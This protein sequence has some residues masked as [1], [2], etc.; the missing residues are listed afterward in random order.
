MAARCLKYMMLCKVMDKD[1]AGIGKFLNGKAMQGYIN[2][3]EIQALQE[4][5]GVYQQRNMHALSETLEKRRATLA[6]DPVV[7]GHLKDL[8]DM[9]FEAHI[10][11]LISPYSR[12][13]VGH[14]ASK[15]VLPTE[16]IEAKLC[17]MILDKKIEG[18]I[19]VGHDKQSVLLLF[20]VPEPLDAAGD[21]DEEK[22][23]KKT[24]DPEEKKKLEE[25][26]KLRD[27]DSG[28]SFFENG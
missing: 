5:A 10:E 12:V 23:K 26:A 28:K 22:A 3:P 8:H 25:A 17:Q 4:V 7:E 21:D 15:L 2:R 24:T 27:E 13:E 11:R 18:V 6:G 20:P 9:L 14:I 1:I 19:D 16:D